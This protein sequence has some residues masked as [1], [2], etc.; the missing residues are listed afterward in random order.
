MLVWRFVKRIGWHS[1]EFIVASAERLI[2]G[3]TTSANA[4]VGKNVRSVITTTEMEL[5]HHEKTHEVDPLEAYKVLK[6]TSPIG[7]IVRDCQKCGRPLTVY[8]S[9]VCQHCGDK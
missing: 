1:S 3:R 7:N 2:Q 6:S 4:N 8:A 5:I 9:S